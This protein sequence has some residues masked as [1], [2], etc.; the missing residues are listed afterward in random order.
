[1]ILCLGL[2]FLARH[3]TEYDH[4]VAAGALAG[5]VIAL[6]LPEREKT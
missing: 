4:S 6:V 1:M 3:L 5:V 2:G